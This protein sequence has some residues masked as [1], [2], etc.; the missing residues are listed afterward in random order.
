MYPFTIYISI[1]SIN[2]T[3]FISRS[4]LSILILSLNRGHSYHSRRYLNV[5]YTTHLYRLSP[6]YFHVFLIDWD[7]LGTDTDN[8]R[9]CHLQTYNIYFC[10]WL[11]DIFQ[12]YFNFEALF[13]FEK[14]FLQLPPNDKVFSNRRI[15]SILKLIL[16]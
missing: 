15:W 11:R 7:K 9:W 8:L 16:M 3:H 5:Y 2:S 10:L 4:V 1:K 12:S 6:R 13:W 14:T